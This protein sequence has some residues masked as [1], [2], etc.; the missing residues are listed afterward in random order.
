MRLVV[1]TRP[2]EEPRSTL[3]TDVSGHRQPERV[4][5]RG[6]RV[7]YCGVINEEGD[8]ERVGIVTR[9]PTDAGDYLVERTLPA[10]VEVAW[11]APCELA[12][13]DH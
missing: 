2:R 1:E 6:D 8:L 7:T 9:G 4:R 12:T 13:G 3:T 10:G 5:Q 11:H